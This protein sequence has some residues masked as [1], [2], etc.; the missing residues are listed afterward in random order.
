MSG[1]PGGVLGGNL[2]FDGAVLIEKP[3]PPDALLD[4]LRHLLDSQKAETLAKAPPLPG[5]EPG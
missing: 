1:Y 4:C 3:F 5:L 2:S